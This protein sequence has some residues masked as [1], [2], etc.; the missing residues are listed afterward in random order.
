MLQDQLAFCGYVIHQ[1]IRF[2]QLKLILFFK[3]FKNIL[4]LT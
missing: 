2:L 4:Q 1:R 3:A